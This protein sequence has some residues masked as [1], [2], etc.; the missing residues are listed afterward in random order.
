MLLPR[1]Y[2]IHLPWFGLALACAT[3]ISCLPPLPTFCTEDFHCDAEQT[4]ARTNECVAT[5][6]LSSTRI[7]WTLYGMQ[8]TAEL[9]ADFAVTALRIAFRDIDTGDNR[10]Y[11]PVVCETGQVYF[12]EMPARF[13]SVLVTV[14][15]GSRRLDSQRIWLD[16][17]ETE[18]SIDFAP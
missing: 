2:S 16:D 1:R 9:C 6:D 15:N 7:S 13:G 17:R 8:P 12:N 5:E 11:E 18:A 14:L 10:S 3:T 4:C